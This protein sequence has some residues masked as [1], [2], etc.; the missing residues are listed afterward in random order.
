VLLLVIAVYLAHPPRRAAT[1][2][3]PTDATGHI[4]S[5]LT[6]AAIAF[7]VALYDGCPGPGAKSFYVVELVAMAGL[8]LLPVV[9]NTKVLNLNSNLVPFSIIMAVGSV[10][11]TTGLPTAVAQ[12]IAARLGATSAIDH[13]GALIRPM[14]VIVTVLMAMRLIHD[15]LG[16]TGPG[17]P[18]SRTAKVLGL[19]P[20]SDIGAPALCCRHQRARENIMAIDPIWYAIGAYVAGAIVVAFI[21]VKFMRR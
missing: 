14:I 5:P 3:G 21:V 11:Y 4:A 16:S 20:P 15:A 18:N 6:A 7:P 10:V 12:L 1:G 13:G 2:N 9:A 19:V 8:G 17:A